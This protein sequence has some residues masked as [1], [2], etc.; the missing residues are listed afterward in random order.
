MAKT[1]YLIVGGS[2]SGKTYIANKLCNNFGYKNV[3]SRTERKPRYA[4][5]YGHIFVSISQA[6]EEYPNSI[7]RTIYN[8]NRYYTL[9]E[10]LIDKDLYIIDVQGVESILRGEY[11]ATN[12]EIKTLYLKT[13]LLIR[14]KNMRKRGDKW[15]DILS[16]LKNDKQE[17]KGF[18]GDYNFSSSD[19]L[20]EWFEFK[21]IIEG[22][23]YHE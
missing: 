12:I 2:G 7:A 10:D 23:A 21:N 13:S 8:G 5:E 11:I 3:I 15:L 14:V 19:K 4:D 6:N 17:F 1:L 20:Y 18:K 22:C 9:I 16:R